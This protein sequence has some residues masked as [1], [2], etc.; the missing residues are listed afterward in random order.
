ML[1]QVAYIC[2]QVVNIYRAYT[3]HFALEEVWNAGKEM[4]EYKGKQKAKK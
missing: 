2:G 1:G 4:D 3:Y